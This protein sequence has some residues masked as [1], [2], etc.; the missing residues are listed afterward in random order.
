MKLTSFLD[1]Q[2]SMYE[3]DLLLEFTMENIAH[4]QEGKKGEEMHSSAY[5]PIY[6][7]MNLI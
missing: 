3:E 6:M 4:V 7:M 2:H 1:A 5:S